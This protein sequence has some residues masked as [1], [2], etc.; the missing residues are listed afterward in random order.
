MLLGVA[1][2]LPALGLGLFA[3]DHTIALVLDGER[4]APTLGPASLYDFGSA[5]RPGDPAW[6]IGAF[7]WW[8]SPDW[9]LR[10]FRPLAS[11]SLA[12]DHALGGDWATRAH[13]TSLALFALLLVVLSRTY[14]A[15]GF[16]ARAALVAT[17]LFAVDDATLV[18]VAWLANRNSLLEVLATVLAILAALRCRP[19]WRLSGA[20]IACA[21]AACLSKESGI[22]APLLAALALR[23]RAR[24]EADWSFARRTRPLAIAL[25]GLS[26]LHLAFLLGAGYGS[27]SAFYPTPWGDPGGWLARLAVLAP[28]GGLASFTPYGPD[29]V[30]VDRAQLVPALV[31]AAVIVPLVAAAVWKRARTSRAAGFL[32]LV[33]ALELLPQAGT[34][35]SSRLLFGPA[36]GTAGLLALYLVDAWDRRRASSIGA[37]A[38]AGF[39]LL[40]ALPCS[41]LSLLAGGIGL[42]RDAAAVD[43]AVLES[44]VGPRELGPR[45]AIVLQPPDAI[46][47]LAPLAWWRAKSDDRD[48][49]FWTIQMG[50]RGLAWTGVDE[51]TFDLA[52]TS[53]PFLAHPF[54]PVFLST[55]ATP[56]VGTRWRTALFEATALRTRS[57]AEGGG[58]DA[59]RLRFDRPIDDPRLRF[60]AWDG[61]RMSSVAPPRPGERKDLAPVARRSLFLP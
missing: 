14:A 41:A 10:F 37:R 42:T 9:S 44:D 60:L 55:T 40:A 26:A 8:T 5:P 53:E 34:L 32:V 58:L 3:D 29:L 47:A 7:P 4:V 56:A 27:S 35:P 28:V 1:L 33:I 54:E 15:L 59:I 23:W 6:E 13:A 43:R 39:V 20:T 31:A 52:S 2:H 25:V 57:P 19:G 21:A 16:S 38:L 22:A 61:A 46:Y 49:R 51:R 24:G 18:P 50:R 12:A 45:E 17:L 48:V 30:V 11:L 36:V